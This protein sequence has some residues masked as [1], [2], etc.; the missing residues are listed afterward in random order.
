MIDIKDFDENFVQ[1]LKGYGLIK[2]DKLIDDIIAIV[3]A[4]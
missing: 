4:K 2:L 1:I 3:S